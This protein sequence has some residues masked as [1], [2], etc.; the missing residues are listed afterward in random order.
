ME[1]LLSRSFNTRHLGPRNQL[2]F[3]DSVRATRPTLEK[4]S[5]SS[6]IHF[7]GIVCIC[8]NRKTKWRSS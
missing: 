3:N 5:V 8:I 1:T 6:F 4:Q 2:K 7:N